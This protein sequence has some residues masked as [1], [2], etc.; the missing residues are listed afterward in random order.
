MKISN[1]L[2]ALTCLVQIASAVQTQ[3]AET[4]VLTGN[5][6]LAR[7]NSAKTGRAWVT[8]FKKPGDA[9][10]ITVNVPAEGDQLLSL[11]YRADSGKFTPVAVNDSAQ[12]TC[13]L[14]ATSGFETRPYGRIHLRAGDNTIRIGTDWG[15]VDIDSIQLSPAPAPVPFHISPKPVNPNAS[16]EA[17]QLYSTLRS[18][19]GHQT[20]A[21]QHESDVWHPSRL[22]HIAK[23]AQGAQP[24]ILGMDLLRYSGSYAPE[25]PDGVIEAALDWSLNRHG[26][27]TLSWHWFSPLGG[28]DPV[29]SSFST[30]KTTFDP[31]LVLDKKTPEYAAFIRDLDLIAI[32][33]Q[34]LRDA[35]VP[36]L[37]RPLHEA[38][39]GWFWWGSRGPETTKK[40]YRIMFD[41]FT[42]V[43]KL[44]N[45]IWVW[46]SMDRPDSLDWYPGNDVVDVIAADLYA[47]DPVRGDLAAAFD[48]LRELYK[49][50]KLLTLGECDY[51]PVIDERA[52]WL[53]FLVWD[54]CIT[55]P[56][57]NPDN[58]INET[59]SDPRVITLNR[60]SS[61]NQ[62]K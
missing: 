29:W 19:F 35:H 56:A 61:L 7:E 20:L 50:R 8:G 33:L 57:L 48:R 32:Q 6:R 1:L 45:L 58:L 21:G 27:V 49:G 60:L 40:L 22:A 38:Q 16:P 52:P 17:K 51:L 10:T 28:A 54:D 24:A 15:Y 14:A 3:E 23:A 36:V 5:T 43:H 39:G 26:I 30:D 25:K 11:T 44:N 4:G 13:W 47:K 34:R 42:R 9:L 31:N 53:W 18:S 46:T 37:W 59:Y 2:L 62:N 12:G 41:R 55:R